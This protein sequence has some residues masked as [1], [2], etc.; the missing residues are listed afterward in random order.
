MIFVA[1]QSDREVSYKVQFIQAMHFW[2]NGQEEKKVTFWDMLHICNVL[3]FFEYQ[4][5]SSTF[6]LLLY[7]QKRENKVC[8]CT[9]NSGVLPT[10][11]SGEGFSARGCLGSEGEVHSV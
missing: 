6:F 10:G 8:M 5:K 11:S 7:F 2:K 4:L 9:Y 3:K 1:G